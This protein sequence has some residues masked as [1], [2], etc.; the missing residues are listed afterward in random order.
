MKEADDKLAVLATVL[1][2]LYLPLYPIAVSLM[3]EM[4]SNTVITWAAAITAV[5][6]VAGVIVAGIYARLTRTLARAADTSARAAL[7]Q[8]A[9]SRI[10]A[11]AAAEQARITRQ[12]FEASHRPIVGLQTHIRNYVEAPDFY[13]L[14]FDAT[15]HGQVPAIL[16]ESRLLVRRGA[17]VLVD[18]I[19]AG[20]GR[21]IF[22][23]EDTTLEFSGTGS[24]QIK[25]AAGAV[26]VELTVSY[27]GFDDVIRTSRTA[28][29]G[30]F[31]NWTRMLTEVR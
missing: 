23:G 27:T 6:T 15:N 19:V 9:A 21:C 14:D 29:V 22:P 24:G 25:G 4:T 1:Y 8:A 16:T 18:L 2:L 26:D 28:L 30:N 17:D 12:I 11:E 20:R 3:G 31:D 10:G 13:S 7:Q 5:A